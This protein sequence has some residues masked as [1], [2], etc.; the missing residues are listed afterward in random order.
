MCLKM[1][2][3]A[4]SCMSTSFVEPGLDF[5]TGAPMLDVNDLDRCREKLNDDCQNRGFMTSESQTRLNSMSQDV[6]HY[7]NLDVIETSRNSCLIL[8]SRIGFLSRGSIYFPSKGAT[9]N[10]RNPEVSAAGKSS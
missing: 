2:T 6:H 10:R 1:N 9:M 3:A 5:E 8:A 4:I 7:P